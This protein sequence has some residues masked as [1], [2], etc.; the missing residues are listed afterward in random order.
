MIAVPHV[1]SARTAEDIA[2]LPRTGVLGAELQLHGDGTTLLE[3][4]LP[5]R[6]PDG[7][8]VP[9]KVNWWSLD[10]GE[11]TPAESHRVH[12]MWLV[13]AGEAD[14]RLGDEVIRVRA[15]QSVF[16]PSDVPHQAVSRGPGPLVGFAVWW[17]PR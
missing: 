13:S 6:F 1:P 2:H 11:S 10:P 14:L 8:D 7:P 9:V 12:E 5:D 3:F 16:I 15:G 17:D 4:V